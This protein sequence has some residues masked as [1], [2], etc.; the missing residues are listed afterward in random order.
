MSSERVSGI[1]RYA[2]EHGWNLLIQDRLGHHP[3]AWNGDGVIATIR[4]DDA[5]FKSIKQMMRRGIPL[6]DLTANRPEVKVPRVTSDHR[7]IGRL[8]ARH[9]AEREFRH[10]AWFSSGWGNV[11]RLRYEGLAENAVEK[12]FKWIANDEIADRRQSEWRAFVEWL[13]VKLAAAPKPLAVLAYDETDAARLLYAAKELD[14][15]VPE[16]LAILSI[17]NNPL[18]CEN[19][20]VP[21][22]SIGQN[23]ERGGYEAAALLDTLMSRKTGSTKPGTGNLKPILIPPAG[24]VTRR[25]TDVIAV[26]NPT[27]REAMEFIKR[28]LSK[29]IG[30]PQIADAIGIRRTKLDALFRTEL[31]RSVGEEIRRLR[32]ARVKL[33]LETTDEPVSAIAR[34]TGYCTPS[35]LTNAFR[36]AFGLTPK[37]WRNLR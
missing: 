24:V 36:N 2:K 7:E 25:S 14:I 30:A 22:S 18:V 3:L 4:S 35:H 20:S 15:S 28:N 13:R 32:F 1:A 17:G 26:A 19:Q 27:V 12:P 23:L 33:L 8:A 34:Q 11:H 6:V 10:V 5:A 21:L 37:F 31:S 16:E 29:P 9:F